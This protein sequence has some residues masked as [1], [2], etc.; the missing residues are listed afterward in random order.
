MRAPCK[1]AAEALADGPV[2][3]L[4]IQARLLGKAAALIETVS[5]DLGASLPPLLPTHCSLQG[6]TVIITVSTSSH[7]AKLRQ[8]LSRIQQAVADHLPEVTGIRIRLQPG[9]TNYRMPG[10]EPAKGMSVTADNRPDQS[11]AMQFAD[12]LAEKLHDSPLREAALRLRASLR[13]KKAGGR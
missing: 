10:I 2:A 5:R 1:T 9:S 13:Q 8:R 12:D 6:R 11:A 3:G 7:A 4:L